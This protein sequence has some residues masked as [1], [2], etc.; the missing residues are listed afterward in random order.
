MD[1]RP[2]GCFELRLTSQG[3]L[4]AV[5][6]PISQTGIVFA[7]AEPEVVPEDNIER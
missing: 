2:E 3:K 1:I 4:H 6:L 5:L 7:E